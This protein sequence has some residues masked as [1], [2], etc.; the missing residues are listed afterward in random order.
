MDGVYHTISRYTVSCSEMEF[1]CSDVVFF[2][3]SMSSRPELARTPN[4]QGGADEPANFPRTAKKGQKFLAPNVSSLQ[5]SCFHNRINIFFDKMTKGIP[6]IEFK[7][8]CRLEASLDAKMELGTGP[9]DFADVSPMRA[10][11]LRRRNE[12]SIDI[13]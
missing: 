12:G 1:Y 7:H 3:I 4:T 10:A 8:F 5:V 13:H 9:Y 11:L 6:S 2:T